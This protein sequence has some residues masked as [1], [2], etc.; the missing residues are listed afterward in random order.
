MLHRRR[1]LS[2]RTDLFLSLSLLSFRLVSSA[3]NIYANV[4]DSCSNVY[5]N[6]PRPVLRRSLRGL[7]SSRRSPRK[8]SSLDP[9]RARRVSSQ[10]KERP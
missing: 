8:N 4:C 2:K 10:R 1:Q 6:D 3:E 7:S 5:E 9:R